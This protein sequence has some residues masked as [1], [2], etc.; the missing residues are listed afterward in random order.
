MEEQ[1][2]IDLR[3]TIVGIQAGCVVVQ[4]DRGDQVLCRSVARLHRP[5]GFFN[6][7]YGRRV[8]IEYSRGNDSTPLLIEVLDD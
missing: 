7:P 4:L 6:V 5:L 2:D 8:K 3:G 1:N